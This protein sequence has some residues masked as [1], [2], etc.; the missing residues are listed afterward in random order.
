MKKNISFGERVNRALHFITFNWFHLMS[1]YV[2]ANY[3]MIS[4]V[5]MLVSYILSYKNSYKK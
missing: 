2:G 3:R 1:S 5:Y 4:S